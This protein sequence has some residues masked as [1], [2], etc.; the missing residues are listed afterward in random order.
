MI[1]KKLMVAKLFNKPPAINR[2]IKAET[3]ETNV[4]WDVTPCSLVDG[5]NISLQFLK[6]IMV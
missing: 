4:F 3:M 6:K 2:V 1:P 5:M